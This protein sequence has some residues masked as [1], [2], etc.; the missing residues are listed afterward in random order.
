MLRHAL[1]FFVFFKKGKNVY[2]S[3][4][5]DV[6]SFKLTFV[7]LRN[8]SHVMPCR[9][10]VCRGDTNIFTHASTMRTWPCWQGV[11]RR[12]FFLYG[13][14]TLYKING[15]PIK[16]KRQ[17]DSRES[18]LPVGLELVNARTSAMDIYI[19]FLNILFI[20]AKHRYNK[21]GLL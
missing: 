5:Q 16:K 6:Q 3:L 8:C 19:F 18:S 10:S 1:S 14:G 20:L 11:R 12:H 9:L 17:N 13:F 15:Y 2:E 7:A 21:T 4:K